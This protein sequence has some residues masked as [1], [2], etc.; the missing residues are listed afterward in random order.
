MLMMLAVIY[1][2]DSR[3]A[4]LGA[5]LAGIILLLFS[6]FKIKKNLFFIFLFIMTILML[7]P[8][9][10]GQLTDRFLATQDDQS[11]RGG[12]YQYRWA[13]WGIAFDEISKSPERF[14]FGYGP[15]TSASVPIVAQFSY[16]ERE[17]LLW[18]WDNHYAAYLLEE[19]I[20]GL[21]LFVL[22]YYLIITRFYK[23]WRP[24]IETTSSPSSTT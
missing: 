7:R 18:S 6:N 15:G 10:L 24:S 2:T 5:F 21:F 23:I 14:L 19:G 13:L 20:L 4:W 9:V 3:G 17:V 12:T 22:L 16:S 8:G 11:F 1:F